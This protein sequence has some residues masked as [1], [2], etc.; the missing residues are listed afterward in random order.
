MSKEI[1]TNIIDE[2]IKT[3][4]SERET[5]LAEIEEIQKAYDIRQQRII[6][7]NGALKMLNELQ[8]TE[9]TNEK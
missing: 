8:T 7:I 3:L 2:K 9:T 4:I 1:K 6:E 5:I